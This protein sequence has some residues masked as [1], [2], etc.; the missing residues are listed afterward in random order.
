MSKQTRLRA[1][2][3]A[4]ALNGASLSL[5]IRFVISITGVRNGHFWMCRSRTCRSACLGFLQVLFW[6]FLPEY[7]RTGAMLL[8]LK[9]F[10]FR[11][12]C[13]GFLCRRSPSC[14]MLF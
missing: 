13:A 11:T 6:H 5:L 2:Q 1:K 10:R 14:L 9:K 4:K 8:C 3:A 12:S 7:G